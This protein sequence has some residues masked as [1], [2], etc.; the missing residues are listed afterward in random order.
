M[1]YK[2]PHIEHIDQVLPAIEGATEFVV[3]DRGNF[4][5]INYLEIGRAH[6]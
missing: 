4:K 6:V 3:A 2:F 5:V 1:F